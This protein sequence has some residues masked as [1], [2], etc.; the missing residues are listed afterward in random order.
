MYQNYGGAMSVPPRGATG[1]CSLCELSMDT[2]ML[3]AGFCDT[4]TYEDP[5][6]TTWL[7]TLHEYR[8]GAMA[9]AGADAQSQSPAS[10]RSMRGS[11]MR[12]RHREQLS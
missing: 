10:V 1:N 3:A 5:C 12:G 7:M 6:H 9:S 2:N 11:P 4:P 8:D